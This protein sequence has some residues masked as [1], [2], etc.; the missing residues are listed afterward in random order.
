MSAAG[1][2]FDIE[3]VRAAALKQLRDTSRPLGTG[4]LALRVG[5]QPHRILIAL[6]APLGAGVVEHTGAAEWQLA[7]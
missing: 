6:D 7:A 3:A 1:K 4:E 5:E 2:P